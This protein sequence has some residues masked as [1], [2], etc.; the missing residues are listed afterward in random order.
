MVLTLCFEEAGK[1]R[2]KKINRRQTHTTPNPDIT[3]DVKDRKI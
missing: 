2:K 3:S 1:G